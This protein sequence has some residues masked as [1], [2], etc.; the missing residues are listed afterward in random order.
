MERHTHL[1][2]CPLHMVELD[3]QAS[4]SPQHENLCV[5][6]IMHLVA[7]ASKK[8]KLIYFLFKLRVFLYT[9]TTHV[10]SLHI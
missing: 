2:N 1:G 6:Q 9:S 8:N 4:L 10:L 3:C 5:P 7:I